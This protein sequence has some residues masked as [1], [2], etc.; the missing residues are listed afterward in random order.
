MKIG[1]QEHRSSAISTSNAD[2]IVVR[3]KDLCGE[4]IGQVSFTDYVWLLLT[5]EMPTPGAAPRCS[6]RHWSR[7]PSM[8]WCPACRRAA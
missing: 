8:G 4:L 6:T 5:G 7:S 3:G 1:G 2:T